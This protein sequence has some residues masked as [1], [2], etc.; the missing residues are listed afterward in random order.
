MHTTRNNLFT[1]QNKSVTR[2]VNALRKQVTVSKHFSP[3]KSDFLQILLSF[4]SGKKLLQQSFYENARLASAC[5]SSAIVP[6]LK[7][8]AY[9]SFSI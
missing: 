2:K 5:D 7:N 9:Q 1:G 4:S 8:N 3:I 6:I